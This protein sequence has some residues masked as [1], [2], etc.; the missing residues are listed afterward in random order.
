MAT[1]GKCKETGVDVAHVRACYEVKAV[2]IPVVTVPA[3]DMDLPPDARKMAPEVL[4]NVSFSEKE[5]AKSLGARWDKDRRSWYFALGEG[6]RD[7]APEGWFLK[8]EEIEDGF[9]E[10]V[11]KNDPDD[12]FEII[13]VY[14]VVTSPN[15]GRQYAKI[16]NGE[17]ESWE[18]A[19]GAMPKIQDSGI[20]LT[21]DRAKELGH[22]YGMCVR[23]GRTL[24]DEGSIEAGIGPICAGKGF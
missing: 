24:T 23:C 4:L 20:R 1:C 18:Y 16:L 5:K 6:N 9:Y 11:K 22:I 7:D 2:S 13:Q 15:T 8:P 10:C 14:K 12:D 21:L 17:T 3:E 19:P